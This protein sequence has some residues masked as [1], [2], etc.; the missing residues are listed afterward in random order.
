[1]HF[2]PSRNRWFLVCLAAS[3]L[4]MAGTAPAQ[5]STAPFSDKDLQN[6]LVRME[7]NRK[8]N[9]LLEQ[10][11][12]SDEFW[13]NRSFD[14]SGKL[15]LDESAKYENIFV[16]GIPYRRKVEENGKP[17][18]GK[19][20]AAE[21][22]R[23]DKAITERRAMKPA[24]K[25]LSFHRT[26]NSPLPVLYLP[27]LFENHVLR[28]EQL[29]GRDTLVIESTPKTDAKPQDDAQKSA[30]DWKETTW[31]D[32]A[33]AMPARLEVECLTDRKLIKKGSTFQIDLTRMAETPEVNGA[34]GKAVWL[35]SSST[36]HGEFKIFWMKGTAISEQ[37]WSNFKRFHVDMRLLD[38][39]MQEMPSKTAN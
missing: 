13:H 5:T 29:N 32:L 39:T 9:D 38:D 31:I 14:K 37:T 34:P 35:Q 4:A 22:A 12:T 2:Y 1:M 36:G 28:R 10:Q 6:L 30:L 27:T 17:L 11:Y 25:R 8:A 18:S 19:E 7:A 23:Y 3:L 21:Q 24:Q 15:T 33:D 16:E 20:A 26:Y